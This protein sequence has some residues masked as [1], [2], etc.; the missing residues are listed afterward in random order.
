[1]IM[2]QITL[3][4][5][6]PAATIPYG[7]GL[8]RIVAEPPDTLALNHA[9]I[10]VHKLN[11]EMRVRKYILTEELS[12]TMYDGSL[13]FT[14]EDALAQ[15]ATVSWT[16]T[17]GYHNIKSALANAEAVAS[18]TDPDGARKIICRIKINRDIQLRECS[19]ADA[20]DTIRE[21]ID[22]LNDEAAEKA[23]L[24]KR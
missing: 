16:T 9:A 20:H 12:V 5:D 10:N 14:I 8:I 6:A 3:S 4:P 18:M 15:N 21:T 17:Y 19:L 23:K 22:R 2:H 7:Q 1:M 13:Y 11:P 24:A